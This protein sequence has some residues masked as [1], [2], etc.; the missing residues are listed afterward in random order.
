MKKTKFNS[1]KG[2]ITTN[3]IVVLY[4]KLMKQ[5]NFRQD[6]SRKQ[7]K[8]KKKQFLDMKKET[9]T[10]ILEFSFNYE[11]IINNA[12]TWKLNWTT[13]QKNVN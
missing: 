8:A 5:T 4:F 12:I 2:F 6:W 13:F 10:D 1:W 11:T 7:E 9:I 3:K